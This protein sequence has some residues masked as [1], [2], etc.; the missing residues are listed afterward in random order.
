M[1]TV[2]SIY[3]EYREKRME[4]FE[5]R[6]AYIRMCLNSKRSASYSENVDYYNRAFNTWDYMC[7]L[8]EKHLL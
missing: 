4:A 2:E 1:N 8:M 3:E 7:K 6:R 5:L